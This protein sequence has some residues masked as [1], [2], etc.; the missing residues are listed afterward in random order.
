MF[1]QKCSFQHWCRLPLD[2]VLD[3][4]FVAVLALALAPA[5]TDQNGFIVWLFTSN[6]FPELRFLCI[7]I[8]L[9]FVFPDFC[10][11][12]KWV[13]FKMIIIRLYRFYFCFISLWSL[14][15]NIITILQCQSANWVS[16]CIFFYRINLYNDIVPWL[17]PW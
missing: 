7:I 1:R 5:Q 13:S 4:V 8:L 12:K 9:C 3:L 14:P 16:K 2:H 11:S 10:L 17:T 15:R 6:I